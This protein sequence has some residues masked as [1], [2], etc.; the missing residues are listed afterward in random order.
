MTIA[1]YLNPS[2]NYVNLELLLI[3]LKMVAMCRILT[4]KIIWIGRKV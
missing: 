4:E 3:F 1:L 2:V